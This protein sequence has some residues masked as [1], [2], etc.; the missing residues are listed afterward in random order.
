MIYCNE[1]EN[2]C[3]IIF[4]YKNHPKYKVVMA[5]NRDEFYERPTLAADFWADKPDIL[6][7]RDLK[8]GGTWLGVNTFGQYAVITNYRDPHNQKEAAPSRGHL[9]QK[10]LEKAISPKSYLEQLSNGGSDYNG[11]NLLVGDKGS[12]Y[13]YSNRKEDIYEIP[14]GVHGLSNNLL[15]INWPKVSQGTMNMQNILAKDEINVDSLF[16]MMADTKLADEKILP[17]TGVG[18]ELERILSASFV[19]SP[20]YGTHLTTVLLI[21]YDHNIQ[22]WERTFI[23]RNP[24]KWDEVFYEIPGSL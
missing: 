15:N 18:V 2:M 23:D 10:Y 22:F 11:F 17:D 1:G 12:L 13:Y 4:A 20:N 8:A 5:A 3:L 21:D 7:G 6:A 14:E 9:V 24:N 19:I 16:T